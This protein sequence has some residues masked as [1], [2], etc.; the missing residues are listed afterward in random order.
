MKKI[1]SIVL[2]FIIIISMGRTSYAS[3]SYDIRSDKVLGISFD[4]YGIKKGLDISP[5]SDVS[6]KCMSLSSWEVFSE[7][8]DVPLNKPWTVAFSSEV[9]MDKIDGMVIQQGNEFIP[10][11]IEIVGENEAVITPV[12]SYDKDTKYTLKI[13]LNN[14][15]RYCMDFYTVKEGEVDTGEFTI[16]NWKEIIDIYDGVIDLADINLTGEDLLGFDVLKD[17]HR[18]DI[19]YNVVGTKVIFKTELKLNT[20]YALRVFTNE[21]KYE[22]RFTTGDLPEI[23]ETGDRIIVKVPAMPEKGF[24]WPYYLAI[25][26]NHYKNENQNY[27]RYLMVDTTNGGENDLQGTE[28]WVYDTL[29]NRY[30]YS[31]SVAEDLWTPMLM[32]VFPRTSVWYFDK[33]GEYNM[34]Y[35]HAFDRDTATLHNKVKDPE[36]RK[37]LEP[38]YE[39][40]GFNIDDFLR[41]DEQL[42]AMFNHAVG[43]L[44]KYGHNVETDKMFL[45][46]Y[47]ASGTFTDRFAAFQPDKVKAVAS[48]GTLDDMILPLSQYEGENLIFPIGTYD[49]K[50]I[51]GRDFD[52][53]KH[54]SVARLIYMGKDDTNNTVPHSDCYGDTERKIIIKL[55]GEP[56]L[57]RAEALIRLYGQSGGKGIFILDKDTEHSASR[58]MQ[59]YILEFFKANR[60][61]DT[62][63]YPVPQNSGQLE[64][65]IY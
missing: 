1:T 28:K 27:K 29:K 50:E 6:M 16:I 45:C 4:E 37:M 46:G 21:D 32:P 18:I 64:H 15:N 26:S 31:V 56:V 36:T 40:K 61:S 14:L 63:E 43:Y 59:D 10:V 48:G 42:V 33:Y 65:I 20:N 62:P 23:Y 24:N 52:L 12:R 17:G 11:K 2:I 57:P 39:E 41:L 44:N 35:E 13:F 22:I 53:Y 25:P 5:E 30:Q 34:F 51:V 8:H 55:W 47:S 7:K 3:G 60:N 58:E 19:D 54:N 38:L 49:Y 9:T